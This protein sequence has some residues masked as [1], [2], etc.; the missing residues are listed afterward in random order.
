LP[1]PKIPST[2]ADDKDHAEYFQELEV[3]L[4]DLPQTLLIHGIEESIA[5][6]L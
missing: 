2:D 4:K 5:T 3:L 1:L 6:E